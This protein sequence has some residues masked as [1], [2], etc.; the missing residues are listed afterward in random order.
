MDDLHVLDLTQA[1]LRWH[2]SVSPSGCQYESVAGNI[3]SFLL[4]RCCMQTLCV[5]RI[6]PLLATRAAEFL[7]C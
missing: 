6:F 2:K 4:S 3:F 7:I 1:K 5:G